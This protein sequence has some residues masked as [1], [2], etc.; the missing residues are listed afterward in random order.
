MLCDRTLRNYVVGKKPF[1]C[2]DGTADAD[3]TNDIVF[4]DCYK[5]KELVAAG[6]TPRG[7]IDIGANVGAFACAVKAQWPDAPVVCIEPSPENY[8][9]ARINTTLHD[10]IHLFNTAVGAETR[11][12]FYKAVDVYENTAGGWVTDEETSLPIKI[13]ALDQYLDT[14]ARRVVDMMKISCNG[15]EHEV[16]QWMEETDNWPKVITGEVNRH[17]A[18][19][20]KVL[21]KKY[22]LNRMHN[23][24]M[25]RFWG[26]RK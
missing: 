7:V 18:D 23:T 8:E 15:L 11:K 16:V 20:V 1:F 17:S 24:D 26:Y 9:L 14:F 12:A 10:R 19:T 22:K 21:G 2:R 4:R 13:T 25:S 5:L 3:I 6:F